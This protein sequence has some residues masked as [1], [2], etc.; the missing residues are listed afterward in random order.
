MKCTVQEKILLHLYRCR[1]REGDPGEEQTRFGIAKVCGVSEDFVGSEVYKLMKA[2]FVEEKRTAVHGRTQRRL[3]AY[4]LTQQGV[5]AAEVLIREIEEL[6]EKVQR[7]KRN[8][9]AH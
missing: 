8:M 6:H 5:F 3:I 7:L 9:E 1:L 2:A 4:S